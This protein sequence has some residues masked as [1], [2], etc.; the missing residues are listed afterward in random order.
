MIQFFVYRMTPFHVACVLYILNSGDG[1]LLQPMSFL[2]VI[3]IIM[4]DYCK[5]PFRD[6]E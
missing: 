2:N 5:I 4:V 3:L 6:A 1:S